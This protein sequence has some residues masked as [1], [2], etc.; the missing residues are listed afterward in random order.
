MSDSPYTSFMS[1]KFVSYVWENGSEIFGIKKLRLIGES[2]GLESKKSLEFMLNVFSKT[3]SEL[4]QI[5]EQRKKDRVFID[6]RTRSIRKYNEDLKTEFYSTDYQTVLG[7]K[8]SK[9]RIVIGPQTDQYM[10]GN[11]KQ[12]APIPEYLEGYHVTLFGPPDSEKM[13]INAMNSFH[14][15]LKN[16]P[17]IIEELLKD[18]KDTPK[19]GA[20]NEDSK[21]PLH[22]D[23]KS[24][25]VNLSASLDHNLEFYDEKRYKSY[26]L[27][28]DHLSHAIKRFPGLALPS[29][30]M[31]Y[32]REPIPLH[33]Y[34]FTL[35][36]F[37][38]WHNPEAMVFYV[39]KLENEEEAR[40]IKNLMETTEKEIQTLHPEYKMGTIRL[41]IVLEN[42]RA[43]F[44][45]NEI[46]DEL[47]PY[48]VG[49]SLGWHDY[50]ASAARVFKN[51]PNYKI[52]VKADPD[53]VIKYIK[54]S[55]D[56]LSDLVGERGGIKV[57]GMYG[58]LPTEYDLESP[59][60]QVTLYGYFRDVLTQMKRN[61]N[62]FWVAHPDFVRIGMAIVEAWKIYQTGDASKLETIIKSLLKE[63]Y[64]SKV[65]DFLY[66]EDIQGLE[67][68]DPLYA[69]SLIVAD[70]GE[71]NIIANNHPDE[72]RYNVFQTL[73]YLTD[74]LTGN[75]C[76]AL[77]TVMENIPV[78]IM[79]DLATCERSRWEVWH[80]IHHGR[81]TVEDFLKIA[82]EEMNFIRRGYETEKKITQVKWHEENAKWYE[83]AFHMMVKLM[84][85]EDP[86]EFATE[87]LLPFTLDEVRSS[88]KPWQTAL[89]IDPAKFYIHDSILRF[90]YFFEI[91]GDIEF[92]KRMAKSLTANEDK[93]KELILNFTKEQIL[94]AASFHGDIGQSKKTLD[95]MAKA[96]QGSVND[97]ESVLNELRSLGEKYI[98]KFGFK[99]LVS[100]KGKT[101]KEMLDILNN[102]I[103][104]SQA[105]EE[106]AAK[107]ALLEITLKRFQNH[108]LNIFVSEVEE[109]KKKVKVNSLQLAYSL[110]GKDINSLSFG[111]TDSTYFEI[112]SL[113][114]TIG[115]FIALD[116]FKQ[117]GISLDSPVN[118]ILLNN[119]SIF[120]LDSDLVIMK[121]LL[122]HTALNMHYVNGV[123]L[124][125]PMPD[126]KEFLKGNKE[127]G[128]D[129]IQTLC[130]T[131][132]E[133]RYSGAGFILVEYI[134]ELLTKKKFKD[135]VAEY[136][137]KELSAEHP[138]ECAHGY[139]DNGNEVQ[140]TRL[141]FPLIAAG[142]M[143]TARGMTQF[144]QNLAHTYKDIDNSDHD[145]AVQMLFGQD[146]GS[147]EFMDAYMGLGVFVI[148]AEENKL[149]LHQ[150]ANDGYRA[151]FLY[152]FDGPDFGKGIT[153]FANAELKA[154]ELISFVVQKF[155][156]YSGMRGINFSKFEDSFSTAGLKQEEIVNRGY[157]ELIFNAFKPN[158]P[159][160]KKG[161]EIDPL[162]EFNR[163]VGSKIISVS[164]DKFARAS[165][166]FCSTKPFFDPDAYGKQGKIMDSWESV[167]HNPLPYDLLHLKLP[168]VSDIE[169]AYISTM[170]HDGNHVTHV[171]L[172]ALCGD[173]WIE[174]LPMC[175][176]FGHS[177][178]KIKLDKR[179]EA[180][181]EV[182]VFIY[183]DGGFTRLGLFENVPDE[184]D[185]V[186]YYKSSIRHKEIMPD[187][188]KAL[189]FVYEPSISEIERNLKNC[190]KLDLASAAFGAKVVSASNEHYGPAYRVISP[191][192]PIDMFDGMES[193][194]SRVKDNE[195]FVEIELAKKSRIN[196]IILDYTYFVN[197]SP[198]YIEIEGLSD[199]WEVLYSKSYV[200]PFAGNMQKIIIDNRN[201]FT[202]IKLK[203]YPCGGLNR[204]HVY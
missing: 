107:E 87:L 60:L 166:L 153:V 101:G 5:L 169:Y 128:Y 31:S 129:P 27:E 79:D 189:Q 133:F 162:D 50:L 70:V 68:S 146:F 117:F 85:D 139:L 172:M 192:A 179:F 74:W 142:L 91:C 161:K 165:N 149:M 196:E 72:I 174:I 15:K 201:E 102:R 82:F 80:E 97:E 69:R 168:R 34:D 14:R 111:T 90:N 46:M 170:F 86:V 173:K 29:Y 56:M 30:F 6:G 18:V 57:G 138:K 38:N 116:I 76:V 121:S 131:G 17:E 81:F 59:S 191:Y 132:N 47:Y 39:P 32:D 51:D 2:G 126:I 150:G 106:K 77:P 175:E 136:G 28:S 124:K 9:G 119:N 20:D 194:R 7:E 11:S 157:S 182:K 95:A 83:V 98:E 26:K 178:K 92:A 123:P 108:P 89:Q 67:T 183:P 110:N 199:S 94:S 37:K 52:P 55:H 197:N 66:A 160:I 63:P 120:R 16:E 151:I 53:I 184:T 171:S 19:W 43:V 99:F 33:I 24:A 154:V 125:T 141:Q 130:E 78:R 45:V 12:V 185:F 10:K 155:L 204:I 187:A 118:E 115:T 186:E 176:I 144:C 177:Y 88:E 195:E 145:K 84:T 202:R 198:M 54:A 122:N 49:A 103:T 96:E 61:L 8:D 156:K 147:I 44:R 13:C 41:M 152:C 100:A 148:E 1:E 105:E 71:S 42:P 62:G 104:R 164:N 188:H 114:K 3:K 137:F 21:T 163:L 75:G 159:E 35:H 93:A 73:Q 193:A 167:R 181:S 203:T 23:L 64:Q 127:F 112:A 143:G 180:V 65:I 109:F 58:I 40:Y 200:K 25:G 190:S 135:I 48:F 22:S 4:Y 36:A 134:I 158:L 113:S 140:D